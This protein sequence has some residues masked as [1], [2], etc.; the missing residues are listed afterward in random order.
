MSVNYEKIIRNSLNNKLIPHAATSKFHLRKIKLL[1]KCNSYYDTQNPWARELY[2]SQLDCFWKMQEL[3]KLND[4]YDYANLTNDEKEIIKCIL[5]V[6]TMMDVAVGENYRML[7]NI[8]S[9]HIDI[10]FCIMAIMLIES[11]H[12]DSYHLI[13]QMIGLSNTLTEEFRQ[14]K[15]MA[16]KY[17]YI[18][19][20]DVSSKQNL[21]TSMGRLAL[22]EGASL[23][24]LNMILML[25]Q[26]YGKMK[27]MGLIAEYANRDEGIHKEFVINLMLTFALEECEHIDFT[28]L[29]EDMKRS[30]FEHLEME[31][32]FIDLLFH[33]RTIPSLDHKNVR[34]Y[35]NYLSETVIREL[36]YDFV[37]EIKYENPDLY[38]KYKY[39][40]KYYPEYVKAST[41]LDNRTAVD[42]FSVV[43]SSYHRIKDNTTDWAEL[44]K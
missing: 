1:D 30:F 11:V 27:T 35:V 40:P 3:P 6:F 37:E 22:T 4:K 34:S 38:A 9:G 26:N 29:K 18:E 21:V 17:E 25:W 14:Y 32:G 13:P 33:N 31:H 24:G 16:K 42:P 19:D 15:E 7:H 10:S 41:N 44:I 20:F 43:S 12:A 23:F 36:G 28:K 39:D 5:Q 2:N 8:F